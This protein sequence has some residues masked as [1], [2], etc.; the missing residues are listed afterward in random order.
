MKKEN[1]MI[2]Y[3]FDNVL[4]NNPYSSIDFKDDLKL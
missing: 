4:Y 3:D 1:K 2:I